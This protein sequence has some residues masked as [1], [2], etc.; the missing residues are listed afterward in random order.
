MDLVF[1]CSK[2]YM[3]V[4]IL[5]HLML[6]FLLQCFGF[7]ATAIYGTASYYRF[8]DWKANPI[9]SSD[10]GISTSSTFNEI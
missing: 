1:C 4:F 6:L 10:N 3:L 7:I 8:A 2:L 9:S 5:W